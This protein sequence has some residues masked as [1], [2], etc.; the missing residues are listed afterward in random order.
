M[1][2]RE[3]CKMSPGYA[4]RSTRA[5]P[6]EPEIVVVS[7]NDCDKATPHNAGCSNALIAIDGATCL[8]F[9]LGRYFY[10]QSNGMC[11]PI[12]L[13]YDRFELSD[14]QSSSSWDGRIDCERYQMVDSPLWFHERGLSETAS[15]YGKK[16]TTSLKIW[17]D[18]K[19]YRVYCCCFSNAGT[20]YIIHR[21]KRIIVG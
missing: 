17:L 10:F 6:K 1:L 8:R 5:W 18:G 3:S 2:T 7:Q 13:T 19:F 21:N 12:T 9:K 4:F 15:G 14:I 20:C 11:E 16:L